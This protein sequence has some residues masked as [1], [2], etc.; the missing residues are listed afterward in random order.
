MVCRLA[1]ER[2]LRQLAE[3]ESVRTGRRCE[4]NLAWRFLETRRHDQPQRRA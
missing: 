2:V 1:R 3:S 4:T